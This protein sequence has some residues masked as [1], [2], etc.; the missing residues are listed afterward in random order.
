MKNR[1]LIRIAVAAAAVAIVLPA[2][3]QEITFWS[4]RQEDRAQYEALIDTFEAA[5]PGITVNFEAHEAANYNTILSTA[6][7]GGEGP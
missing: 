4:W 1:F 7:A 5:N 2:F 3:A 6:L